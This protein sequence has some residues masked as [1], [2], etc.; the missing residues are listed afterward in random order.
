MCTALT[1][2]TN[3]NYFGRT[4]DL[5]YHYNEKVVIVP[6]KFPIKYKY[7]NIDND[8]LSM[9]GIGIVIDNFP[10]FY[11]ACNEF[12]L[13]ICALNL[14]FSTKY[15]SYD[16]SKINITSYE[17]I[18]YILSTCKNLNDTKEILS[19]INIT[20]DSFNNL[21]PVSKLHF[22]ISYNNESLVLEIIDGKINIYENKIGVLTN[23]PQ[24]PFHLY[25]LQNYQFFL[26]KNNS[27]NL[28]KD[29]NQNN[30]IKG[31]NLIGLPGDYTSSSRYIKAV[32]AKNNIIL[33]DNISELFN[34]FNNVYELP[35]LNIKL[36]NNIYKT[37]YIV[38]YNLNDK[39]LYFKTYNNCQI[40]S[41]NL[42]DFDKYNSNLIE[43]NIFKIEKIIKLN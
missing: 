10:L 3:K 14:P 38:F 17:V 26:D 23:E 18:L 8:H 34:I 25:N 9:I 21:Y 15:S 35:G 31:A 22:L 13:G 11:D 32:F 5:E 19:N 20:Y 27:S 39:I 43:F 2:K 4:L 7:L 12:G 37:I 33:N 1:I 30:I 16:Y 29:I 24:F 41:V 36:L 42:N 6:R 28:S 40:Y